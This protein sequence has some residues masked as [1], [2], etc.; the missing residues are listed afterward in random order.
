M[1]HINASVQDSLLELTGPS[2]AILLW[3]EPVFEL[4]LKAKGKAGSSS[5]ED[6]KILCLDFFGYN[7]ICYKGS[8][9]YAKTEVVSS[10]HSTVEVRFAHLKRSV[11][12]TITA[13]ISK[14]SG[15]FSA[16]LTACNTSIGEDVVLLDTRGQEVPVGEDGEVRLQRRVVVVEE[17]A[18]LI[19]GIKAEQ[20]AGDTAETAESSSKL[21]KKFGFY[22]KSALR[23]ERYFHVGSSSLHILVA[24]SLLPYTILSLF[25][26]IRHFNNLEESKFLYLIKFI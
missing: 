4:D 6:D 11:E 12:A 13:R 9:S 14:G 16:R 26:I 1:H 17:R 5:S 21:E 8:L 23:N 2:R 20:I 3:D 7:N 25:Q 24:W 10:K 19:L 18:Q 22:A 15:N